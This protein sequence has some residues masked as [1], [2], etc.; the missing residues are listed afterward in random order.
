MN[1]DL[2]VGALSPARRRSENVSEVFLT[3]R[4]SA[5]RWTGCEPI[6]RGGLGLTMREFGG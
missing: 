3:R 1:I 4:V 5:V 2:V 6:Q